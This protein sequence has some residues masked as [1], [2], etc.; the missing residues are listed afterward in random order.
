MCGNALV[1]TAANVS[2]GG[3]AEGAG[4]GGTIIASQIKLRALPPSPEPNNVI[5][6]KQR[7]DV[8]VNMHL[9]CVH[10]ANSAK[11]TAMPIH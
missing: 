5:L 8:W 11:C 7:N 4:S 2:G 9:S 6:D 1:L 10:T 3:W